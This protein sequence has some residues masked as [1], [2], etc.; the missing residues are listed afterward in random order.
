MDGSL[1]RDA[2]D[3]KQYFVAHGSVFHPV[4]GR[5]DHAWIEV[6]MAFEGVAVESASALFCIDRSN[7]N[8]VM[9][10]R[11]LYYALGEIEDVRRYTWEQA[12]RALLKHRHYG[13]WEV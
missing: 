1:A 9:M 10:P 6:D 7:G 8:D 4:S 5:H 12:K 13:P 2:R 3:G 11:V